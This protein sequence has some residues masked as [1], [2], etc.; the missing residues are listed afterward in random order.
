MKLTKKFL[1]FYERKKI[2]EH[3]NNFGHVG[4]CGHIRFSIANSKVKTFVF[5][6]LHF[7]L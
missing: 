2:V 7:T 1:T 4:K 3:W 5:A 6:T